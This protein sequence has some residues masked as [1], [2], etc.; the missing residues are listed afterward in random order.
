MKVHAEKVL[1]SPMRREQKFGPGFIVYLI[2][3]LQLSKK[4][5]VVPIGTPTI[6]TVLIRLGISIGA[7]LVVAQSIN[8]L[9]ARA[10]GILVLAAVFW[11]DMKQRPCGDRT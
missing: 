1:M 11:E 2:E 9:A 8:E 4:K 3:R 6:T 7:Y 10:L 5:I